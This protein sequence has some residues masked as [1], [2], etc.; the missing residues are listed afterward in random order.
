MQSAQGNRSIVG[1][2]RV[3][4]SPFNSNVNKQSNVV[5]LQPN[6]TSDRLLQFRGKGL[7]DHDLIEARKIAESAR[8]AS[9]LAPSE[10]AASPPLNNENEGVRSTLAGPNEPTKPLAK[11]KNF[12]IVKVSN[13]PVG[14]KPV[15]FEGPS[16]QRNCNSD[17]DDSADD[18]DDDFVPKR[19]RFGNSKSG[20]NTTNEQTVSKELSRKA[21]GQGRKTPATRMKEE[22]V[23]K[24]IL[25]AQEESISNEAFG[26]VHE[27]IPSSIPYVVTQCNMENDNDSKWTATVRVKLDTKQEAEKWLTDFE[28]ENFL[29]FRV[30]L[31]KKG[32]SSRLV[33]KRM[34]R[35]H[36]NTVPRHKNLTNEN[37]KRVFASKNTG[38]PAQI[39]ITIN[40][41][42]PWSS[43]MLLKDY[44]CT[45]TIK[46]AHN[47]PIQAVDALRRRRPNEETKK[48]FVE[49]LKAGHTALSAIESHKF[50]LQMKYGDDYY[51]AAGDGADCPTNAWVYRL[52]K[53]MC[54]EKYGPQ[55]GDAMVES[56]KK[57][58][59]EYNVQCKSE[60]AK[61]EVVEDRQHLVFVLCS[62]L[63]KRAHRLLKSAGEIMFA[64]AS[65]T[66]DC[67]N[68]R[69]FLFLTSSVA[70]A[71]PLGVL[72]VTSES[73]SVLKIA[74]GLWKSLLPNDA[75]F[76]RGPSVG[77]KLIMTDDSRS[78]RNAFQASFPDAILLLC[79][80]HLL[81]AFWRYLWDREQNIPKNDRPQ[82]LYLL[83]DLVY[84]E[85]E[86]DFKEKLD[87]AMNSPKLDL[88]PKVKK[89]IQDLLPR[90]AEWAKFERENLLTRGND[91]NNYSEG[92]INVMKT[93]VLVRTKAFNPVQLADFIITRYQAYLERRLVDIVNNRA[94][95]PF[96]SRYYIRAEKLVDLKCEKLA[97]PPNTFLVK[98]SKKGSEY[99]VV[100]DLEVC[101][102]PH[103][104]SGNPCKHL[105]AV[106]QQFNICS[107]LIH[108]LL[109]CHNPTMR[110]I[111]FEVAYGHR[112]VPAGWF[113]GLYNEIN[114][115]TLQQEESS[116]NDPCLH[117]AVASNA[118]AEEIVQHDE[119]SF[120]T[121]HEVINSLEDSLNEICSKWIQKL[122]DNPDT[123][124]PAMKVF[125]Q[126]NEKFEH[127]E[128]GLVSA[129][130]TFGKSN[131]P[132]AVGHKKRNQ[133]QIPVQ[134]TSKAR[135]TTYLGGKSAQFTGRPCKSMNSGGQTSDH[136][137]N[138][139][140]KK[141][142][143]SEPVWQRIP[144]RVKMPAPH[145]L[146]LCVD[147][148]RSLGSKH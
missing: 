87:A 128:T 50:D 80:F 7:C 49:M 5:K 106:V 57:L 64:D 22:D 131:G 140:V 120:E 16:L 55:T 145:S 97:S 117:E 28:K 126:Q 15:D 43:D 69:L 66:M 26:K 41:K 30:L 67:L 39:T 114:P 54:T 88:Y 112:N 118:V 40:Q 53:I 109:Q 141:V 116:D 31:T 48:K 85:N 102:C 73:E 52:Y 45:I 103:G 119:T 127:S 75:F 47:H 113:D 148:K 2:V 86:S 99:H 95:N 32:N 110:K 29:D 21:G 71:V 91:T 36:H 122:K 123:F 129:L 12:Q 60:C 121:P 65:G 42:M 107:S 115:P 58:C 4:F 27:M 138:A 135:R 139:A 24:I 92:N 38:C 108:P 94:L 133:S 17:D 134:P 35:C 84:A 89:H 143:S 96:K 74:I 104:K 23:Q 25:K 105:C 62:P 20:G 124:A 70:G 82:L 100:M 83:K 37:K 111:L 3:P 136:S 81:Q 33:F 59:E 130:H 1:A 72:I 13:D 18:L 56:M 44:P 63:M 144:N 34:Y 137:Y 101:S 90:A 125:V 8:H 76:G 78:E 19:K 9:C 6:Y 51:Q 14:K 93:K 142:N 79:L 61:V 77:P 146:Q 132:F 10:P 46:H 98:N 68:C 11:P 147:A